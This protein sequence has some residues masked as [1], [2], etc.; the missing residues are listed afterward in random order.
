MSIQMMQNIQTVCWI[1]LFA[2]VFAEGFC[3]NDLLNLI[4]S[5]ELDGSY[6]EIRG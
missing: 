2:S 3:L 5:K 4:Q 6:E 1:L